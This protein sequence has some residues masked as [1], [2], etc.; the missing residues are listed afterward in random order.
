MFEKHR[1][2]HGPREDYEYEYSYEYSHFSKGDLK[3]VILDLIKDKPRY[4]YEIIRALE[5]RSLGFY[6]PSPGSVYPT[7]QMLEEMGY[8]ST[9]EQ[10][11]KKVYTI[12]ENGRRFLDERKDLADKI[13]ERMKRH[14]NPK[15]VGE[16]AETMLVLSRVGRK[17]KR[18]FRSL[19]PNQMQ[20][21]KE[22][23]S[24]ACQEIEAILE[25]K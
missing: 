5:D 4:G 1:V 20:R 8:A 13:R 7:L 21:I 10:D 9:I 24:R 15:D 17:M 2:F 3:Y 6:K 14:W 19:E 23:V 22:I 25:E 12:T 16:F 18:R 11:G